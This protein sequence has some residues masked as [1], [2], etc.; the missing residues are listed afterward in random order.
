[1]R[2]RGCGLIDERVKLHSFNHI[3]EESVISNKA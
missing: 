1:M 3:K 2:E